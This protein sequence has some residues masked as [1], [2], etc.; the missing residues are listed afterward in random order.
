ML[1][2]FGPDV[3]LINISIPTG[4]LSV[5]E[6][7]AR[8]FNILEHTFPGSSS[9]FFTLQVPFADPS[10]QR[11][12]SFQSA[13]YKQVGFINSFHF[14]PHPNRE[15]RGWLS[16]VFTWPLACWSCQSSLR[17]PIRLISMLKWP[18]SV[19]NSTIC[20]ADWPSLLKPTLGDCLPFAVSPSISGGCDEENF[21]VLVKY[22][23]QGLNFVTTVG[24][25]MLTSSLAREYNMMENGT[26]LSF[27]VPFSS[28]NVAYE[29]WSYYFSITCCCF[30]ISFKRT[31]LQAVQATS[32]RSRLDV[33]LT[34]PQT[35]KNL[36]RFSLSCTFI[37]TLTGL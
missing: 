18:T 20:G 31:S 34:D 5:E 6:C 23:T 4:V 29:V 24:K 15:N 19:C 35:Q 25:Q 21:Y 36:E 33:M 32:M 16:S 1:G 12:A 17:F 30:V 28:L 37:K 10:V 11:K 26:H 7:N 27:S 2:S 3:V 8:D 9:K 13:L 14:Y 22:G